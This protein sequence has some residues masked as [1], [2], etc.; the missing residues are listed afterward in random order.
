MMLDR[1]RPL[2]RAARGLA[3]VPLT[4]ALLTCLPDVPPTAIAAP[5]VSAQPPGG[6][7]FTIDGVEVTAQDYTHAVRGHASSLLACPEDRLTV[8]DEILG[9]PHV[10][11]PVYLVDG[12]AQRLVYGLTPR[13]RMVILVSRFTLGPTPR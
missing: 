2:E 5:P 6:G 8:R 12:C 11:L 3:Y 9:T 13:D 7:I 4:T 10:Q 1:V